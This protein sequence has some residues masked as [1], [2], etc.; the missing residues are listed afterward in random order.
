[1]SELKTIHLHGVLKKK[2]GATFNLVVKTPVQ[3]VKALCH[4]LPG[5][6]KEFE[7]HDY[8]V[9][10]GELN[11]GWVLDEETI[12]M[13]VGNT[14]VHFIP[15]VAGAKKGGIAKII[16]G[17]LLIGLAFAS[18]GA[19]LGFLGIS[20]TQAIVMGGLLIFGGIAQAN[21]KTPSLSLSSLES[22]ETRASFIFNGPVNT[23]EQGNA[24]PVVY[25]I[26]RVGSQV[27]SSGQD[28]DQI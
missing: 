27:I 16:T 26:M 25:G 1:M 4:L 7:K 11:N 9:V 8:S 28:T 21:A 22:A 15:V 17:V 18:G 12:K 24:I 20:Q 3:A 19:A 14:D 6:R 10:K 2:F 23:T 13:N 5:F